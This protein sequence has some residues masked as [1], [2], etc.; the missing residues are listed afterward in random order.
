MKHDSTLAAEAGRP[1]TPEPRK[2]ASTVLVIDDDPSFLRMASVLAGKKGVKIETASSA[3]EAE[4]LLRSGT[5]DLILSDYFMPGESGGELYL[6]FVQWHPELADRFILMTGDG[7]TT[8]A[9]DRF[10]ALGLR[11][12]SK[13]FFYEALEGFLV[14]GPGTCGAKT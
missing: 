1:L 9:V 3:R 8:E 10:R 2:S 4:K 6:H 11:C 7:V 14:G 12:I 13:V 5:Y